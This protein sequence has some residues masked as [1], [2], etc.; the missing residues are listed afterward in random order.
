VLR[1]EART[2]WAAA[3]AWLRAV[4]SRHGRRLLVVAALLM[5][6]QAPLRLGKAY[7]Q[8]TAGS[9]WADAY[10]LRQFW[11]QSRQWFSGELPYRQNSSAVLPPASYAIMI[12]PLGWLGETTVRRLYAGASVVAL[13]WLALLL[14]G[15][16]GARGALERT[17]IVLTVCAA[18]ATSMCVAVGQLSVFIVPALLVGHGLLAPARRSHL[19]YAAAALLVLACLVKP[20]L[21]A[22]FF[23]LLLLTPGTV[24]PAVAT[25]TG[26]AA[27]TL[28]ATSFQHA[29]LVEIL[30]MWLARG[31]DL[32]FRGGS[33]NLLIWLHGLGLGSWAF[34]GPLLA[35]AALG[36]WI[37]R[38]RRADP[39]LLLGVT[40]LVA[41]LWT[42]HREYDDLIILLPMMALWRASRRRP[43][44]GN[45]DVAA[46]CVLALTWLATLAPGRYVF[47]S[48]RLEWLVPTLFAVAW[49][50]ALG[51]LLALVRREESEAAGPAAAA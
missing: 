34:G 31:A 51:V 36:V 38:H 20:N 48:Q 1:G 47:F 19:R 40:A 26:Y 45:V 25:A 21:S 49:I 10:D 35:I 15:A 12:G 29:P 44:L 23:W 30:G 4:W 24:V 41:R 37:A 17:V 8:V 16:S 50:A 42:Y 33:T 18:L 39:W 5:A 9:N 32:G 3:A 6:V 22:P 46:G 27:L 11:R 2:G 13:A 14:V 43:R 28:F 7:Y